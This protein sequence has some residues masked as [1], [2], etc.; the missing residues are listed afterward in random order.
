MEALWVEFEHF[1]RVVKVPVFRTM[2]QFVEEDIIIPSGPKKGMPFDLNTQ[3][4]AR[5]FFALVDAA[6]YPRFAVTG[7]T[8]TGKTLAC[9]VVPAMYYLFERHENVGCGIPEMGMAMDKWRNDFEP[10]IRASKYADQ[11]PEMGRG[12]KGGEFESITFKNG[13]TLYFLTAAGKD[14]KRSGKTIRVLVL[15]E[16]DK[17][18][19]AGAAS[20]ESD[21]ITQMIARTD[22]FGTMGSLVFMEC[23]VSVEKGRIWQEY[24]GGTE[25]R[26]ALLCQY[27]K[28]YVTPEREH[29][30]GWQTAKNEIEARANTHF[31]C[32]SCNAAWTEADRQL[33]NIMSKLV[34]RGQEVSPDGEVIG[35][36][37]QTL[38]AGFR[39][40]AANNLLREAA[41]FGGQEWKAL[42]D[43][44]AENKEKALQQFV[45]VKPWNGATS[46]MDI[47]EDVV[48]SRLNGLE[49]QQVP[50]DA[51]SLVCHIDLHLRWHYWCVMAVSPG[52]VGSVVDYG[53]HMNPD[54]KIVGADN[55]IR[56]GL[57]Q[58]VE[59]IES[60]QFFESDGRIVLI[61]F[62]LIDAGYHQEIGLQFVSN[63]GRGRWRLVKGQGVKTVKGLEK[64]R[65][66]KAP[67]EDEFPGDHW[68]DSRRPEASE[69]N[70]RKWWLVI[71]DTDHFLH[72][73]HS[74]FSA[75]TF[76]EDRTTRRPGSIALFGTEP[77]IHLRNIDA[78]IGRSNFAQQLVGW[79][80][81]AKKKVKGKG[82]QM[83]WESQW[84]QDHWQDTAYGC[85]VADSVYRTYKTVRDK[86]A[87]EAAA[88]RSRSAGQ[89]PKRFTTPDGRPFLITERENDG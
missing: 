15:T 11:I 66:P 75:L 65:T 71:A 14:N 10:A 49:R 29:L 25:S 36:A 77:Q 46:G 28:K 53:I 37:P 76:L 34:H 57:Q 89:E 64:Y 86:R 68:F 2:S 21:P 50:D 63:E 16:V 58:C 39:W 43:P 8:Q 19:A 41:D 78:M 61:D 60:I 18:D 38:T 81:R 24:T 33:S 35:E 13:A 45:W 6:L 54:G 79:V 40:S 48:A 74:G 62:G 80:W 12:S 42:N 69:S 47:T 59:N 17:Y 51:E 83:G 72:Q 52:K 70:H 26:L 27:C 55:A 31:V 87:A 85:L 3:P 84:T 4:F 30:V 20:K 82:E 56:I 67:S 44:D 22:S 7:P 88:E 32:P 9:F 73:L 5:H 23:T 1:T